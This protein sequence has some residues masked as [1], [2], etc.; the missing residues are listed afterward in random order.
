MYVMSFSE[1][2][3]RRDLAAWLGGGTSPGLRQGLQGVRED[4]PT[5]LVRLLADAPFMYEGTLVRA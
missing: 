4:L 1:E 2:V 5:S 3:L